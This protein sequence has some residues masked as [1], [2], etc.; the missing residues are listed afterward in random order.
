MLN[1]GREY[2]LNT[3]DDLLLICQDSSSL[4]DILAITHQEFQNALCDSTNTP[5][6]DYPP[7]LTRAELPINMDVKSKEPSNCGNNVYRAKPSNLNSSFE[8]ENRAPI[9]YLLKNITANTTAIDSVHQLYDASMMEGHILVCTG[10]YDV[11]NFLC[12]LR[13][14]FSKCYSLYHVMKDITCYLQRIERSCV[15]LS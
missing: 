12:T 5:S 14:L 4:K 11:F 3:M 15:C 8:N 7:K 10:S 1:P 6:S 9:C 13:Y 2:M